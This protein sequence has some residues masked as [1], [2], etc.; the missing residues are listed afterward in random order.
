MYDGRAIANIILDS[1]AAKQVE[2]T[3]L[4]MQKVLYFCHVWFLVMTGRNLVRHSFEAW[5]FGPVLPYVYREFRECEEKPIRK[6][7]K[8]LDGTVGKM[9]EASCNI[10]TEDEYTLLQIIDFYLHLSA[11]QLVELSHEAGGPWHKVWNHAS[12]TNPGMKILNNEIEEYYARKQ[13]PFVIQ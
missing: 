4:S 8:M 1:A 3:N 7:A 6:K 5:E 13:G 10:A 11:S 9:I 12:A 2:V